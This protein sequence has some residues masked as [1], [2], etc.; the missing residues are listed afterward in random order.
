MHEVPQD[1]IE[2]SLS[3]EKFVTADSVKVQLN[4][5]AVVPDESTDMKARILDA[6]GKVATGVEWYFTNLNRSKSNSGQ[7]EVHAQLQTRVEDKQLNGL[8]ERI[9]KAGYPG[10]RITLGGLDYS[11]RKK[12]LD[13]ET[14][15]MRVEAYKLA[16]E[17][18][19]NLND[20]VTDGIGGE[21][22]RVGQI[23]FGQVNPYANA[24]AGGMRAA[25]MSLES[26]MY[27]DAGGGAGDSMNLT[28]KL[29]L[30]FTVT[31]ARRAY[32]NL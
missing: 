28:Q 5:V 10:L 30:H 26:T 31:A 20:V 18:I 19:K 22:W 14:A 8:G 13:E 16:N 17:E 12:Q 29:T 32:P 25:A 7:E 11:P 24:K 9:E 21:K 2:I 3:T 4:V 15:K 1:T 23:Q 27:A 6:L